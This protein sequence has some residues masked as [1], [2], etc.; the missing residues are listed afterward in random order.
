ML[1]SMLDID[2]DGSEYRDYIDFYEMDYSNYREVIDEEILEIYVDELND[3]EFDGDYEWMKINLK[4]TNKW[5]WVFAQYI[6]RAEK[7]YYDTYLDQ[8]DTD[9]WEASWDSAID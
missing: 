6:Q 3:P 9:R 5:D 2:T 8:Y 7:K 4:L 1:D